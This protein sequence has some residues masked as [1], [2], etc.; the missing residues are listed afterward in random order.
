MKQFD[1]FKWAV[2]VSVGAWTVAVPLAKYGQGWI[3]VA[4]LLVS[5]AAGFVAI[6]EF[7]R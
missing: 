1:W 5:L 4:L 7:T 2:V 6:R 3:A